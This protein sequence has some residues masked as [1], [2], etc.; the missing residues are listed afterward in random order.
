[1]SRKKT[2]YKVKKKRSFGFHLLRGFLKIFIRRPKLINPKNVGLEKKAIYLMNHSGARGPIVFELYFPVFSTPWG[3]H[4]MLGN[5]RQRW[6]YL[7][8]VFY[9]QKLHWGKARAGFV[10]TFFAIISK[11]VYGGAGLIGT[12]TD[13]RL[14]KTM[15][16]S[17]A[18]LDEDISIV[19]FPEDSSH[20]YLDRCE[21]FNS[22]FVELSRL[23]FKKTGEDLPVYNV[24]YSRKQNK[25][26]VGEP[27]KVNEMLSEGMTAEEVSA[28]F[29][30][31]H[32]AMY[33][34]FI[35][36]FIKRKK[37]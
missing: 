1:M 13:V 5:Y 35:A 31:K 8:N 16:S 18:V 30:A 19:I 22:G 10:A 36:P 33:D 7:Y 9:R 24:Y 12:Y 21:T 17:F 37:K 2:V 29:L 11:L 26:I 15:H 20:G 23:Y 3:A 14:I 25:F 28:V 27:L 34:E 32:N 4:E 6:N